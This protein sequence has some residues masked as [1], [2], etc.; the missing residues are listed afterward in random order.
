MIHKHHVH[1]FE[2][3]SLMRHHSYY[4]FASHFCVAT[5]RGHLFER[6]F[7]SVLAICAKKE[8]NRPASANQGLSTGSQVFTIFS[9][10]TGSHPMTTPP[11]IL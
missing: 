8:R 10:M 3:L 7:L 1:Q 6:L 2:I 9:F 11:T 4:F 5:I